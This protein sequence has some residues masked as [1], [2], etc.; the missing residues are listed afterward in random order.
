M[1]SP[2]KKLL[3]ELFKSS[4]EGRKR[5]TLVPFVV[6]SLIFHA[7]FFYVLPIIMEKTFFAQQ[8]E[9]VEVIPLQL[10]N[11]EYKIADISEPENQTVP[12]Q[13]KFIGSY[14]SKVTKEAVN[15][16]HPNI[17]SKQKAQAKREVKQSKDDLASKLFEFDK[18]LFGEVAKNKSQ[19]SSVQVAEGG[20]L[21]HVDDYFPDYKHA[22]KTYLNVLRYPGI[23]YFVRLKRVFK[24][25]W[26]PVP[27]ARAAYR[28]QVARGKLE[29][30]MAVSVNAAGELEE[31]FAAFFWR[32]SLRPRGLA[33]RQRLGAFFQ[34][35]KKIPRR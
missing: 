5:D 13:A 7:F 22:D 25:T 33:N 9:L 12:D 30:V 31:L 26:N 29:V 16:R 14:N 34:T 32:C 11:N 19:T 17:S 3:A 15:N 21:S 8:E 35:S 27:A 24:T 28:N 6:I 2:W 18:D 20:E 10:E 23:D 1:K 4:E